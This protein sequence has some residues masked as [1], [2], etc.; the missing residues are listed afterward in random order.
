MTSPRASWNSSHSMNVKYLGCLRACA[1]CTETMRTPAARR[2]S[3]EPAS[4]AWAGEIP[5][6]RRVNEEL[7][8]SERSEAQ[9]G[10]VVI[11][12]AR[13]RGLGERAE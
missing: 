4:A 11:D 12:G 2:P 9:A 6:E 7:P 3:A 5:S 13:E 1:S 8:Q 10:A